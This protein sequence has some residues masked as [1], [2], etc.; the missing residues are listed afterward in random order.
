MPLYQEPKNA[1]RRLQER[2][3]SQAQIAALAH[4]TQATI[5]RILSG[6]KGVDYR[7]VDALRQAANRTRKAKTEQVNA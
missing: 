6:Q 3:F 4:T 2:E 1:I 7:I 5:C